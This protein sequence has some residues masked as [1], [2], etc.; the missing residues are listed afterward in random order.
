MTLKYRTRTVRTLVIFRLKFHN[1]RQLFESPGI[2]RWMNKDRN[3]SSLSFLCIFK[4]TISLSCRHRRSAS[5]LW[6]FP[7]FSFYNS[8]CLFVFTFGARC[9]FARQKFSR[10]WYTWHV[11]NCVFSF[12]D[13]H[14]HWE[15]HPIESNKIFIWI[16]ANTLS[17]WYYDKINLEPNFLVVLTRNLLDRPENLS[18]HIQIQEYR[19]IQLSEFFI[20]TYIHIHTHIS[21]VKL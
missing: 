7:S 15:T 4:Q 20:Y 13:E 14:T 17:R 1:P 16:R 2:W 18:D 6:N 9:V 21:C 8:S 10:K 3:Y 5:A 19:S 12:K 11:K